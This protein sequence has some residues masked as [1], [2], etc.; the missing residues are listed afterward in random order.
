[1]S[2]P[3]PNFNML[4]K[5][6]FLFKFVSLGIFQCFYEVAKENFLVYASW[7]NPISSRAFTTFFTTGDAT[8]CGWL[9]ISTSLLWT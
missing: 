3:V 8:G 1:M 2:I 7:I 9:Q 5:K 4:W 6:L